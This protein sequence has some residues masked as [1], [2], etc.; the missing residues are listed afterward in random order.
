MTGVDSSTC[1]PKLPTVDID[2][3]VMLS[4]EKLNASGISDPLGKLRSKVA[5]YAVTPDVIVPW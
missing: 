3:E 4:R 1:P 2:R 5:W